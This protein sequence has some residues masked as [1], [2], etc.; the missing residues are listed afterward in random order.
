[1]LGIEAVF[2]GSVR[3]VESDHIISTH[4][5]ELILWHEGEVKAA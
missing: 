4:H 3:R 1:M 5:V 2:R